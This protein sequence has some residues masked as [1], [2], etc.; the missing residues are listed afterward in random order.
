MVS[1][2]NSSEVFCFYKTQTILGPTPSP[3]PPVQACSGPSLSVSPPHAVFSAHKLAS[4]RGARSH[5][6]SLLEKLLEHCSS[7]LHLS[8]SAS[9][10]PSLQPKFACLHLYFKHTDFP[11]PITLKELQYTKHLLLLLSCFSRV[12]LCVT[13]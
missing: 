7:P 9:L 3:F 10:A 2:V 5:L 12:R 13:P 11:S 6:P 4:L 1:I 8:P